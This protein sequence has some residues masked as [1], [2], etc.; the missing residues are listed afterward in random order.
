MVRVLVVF[1]ARDEVMT[2][3]FCPSDTCVELPLD[4]VLHQVIL[5]VGTPEAPHVR[6]MELDCR[7]ATWVI[8]SVVMVGGTGR[9]GVEDVYVNLD[10]ELTIA[11]IERPVERSGWNI[12][13][14]LPG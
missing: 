1:L 8:E 7:T 13:W 10:D 4:H 5:G 9:W 14:L 2:E 11:Y 12:M 3:M 6:L